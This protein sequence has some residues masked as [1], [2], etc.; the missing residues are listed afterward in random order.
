[1]RWGDFFGSWVVVAA[2]AGLLATGLTCSSAFAGEGASEHGRRA[3]VVRVAIDPTYPPMVFLDREGQPAGFDV[4]LA[5][6]L[7]RRLG[8]RVEFV[9][10][11]WS[12]II[13]GLES[14]R[15][16]LIISSMNITAERQQQVAFVEYLRLAQV[17]ISQRPQPICSEYDL[18]GQIVS[19]QANTTSHRWVEGLAA[20]GIAVQRILAFPQATDPFNAIKAG[21]ADVIVVDEPVGR[22]YARR[23][24]SFLVTG[25]AL[26]PEPVGIA[27]RKE[28]RQLQRDVA[29]AVAEMKQDGTFTRLCEDWFGGE[30][31]LPAADEQG[32]WSFSRTIALPRL[33]TGM[34]LTLQLTG[35]GGCLGILLGLGLS[36]VRLSRRRLARWFVLG[37]ITL[38]RGTPLLLQVLFF[39][40]ALP[41]LLGL[42]LSAF[43]AAVLALALNAAAYVSEI[44][45]AAIESIDRGQMEAARAL[46]MSYAQAMGRIILPQTYRR[47]LPPLVNELAALSKDTSLVMVIALPEL[48][49]Q[50]QRLAA[51]Y[52]R[53]WE[54]YAWAALGYLLIVLVLTGLAGYLERRLRRRET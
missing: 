40:F 49:Y 20:K 11:D 35:A 51:S 30:F 17:F 54:V 28:D 1:M 41:L 25:R 2:G 38:F 43:A 6:E 50:T 13:A 12:G 7:A 4:D 37:Y 15:Y 45:R 31:G 9:V 3:G 42:R 10:M 22:Y 14:R 39:Y 32:F 53:P 33:L 44:I 24:P 52:L 21:Q 47:L 23:D 26:E 19:T 27:L 46:G 5:R 48:L 8:A 18:V 29:A 36:L 34:G 16:D